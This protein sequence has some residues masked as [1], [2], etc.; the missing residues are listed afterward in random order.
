MEDDGNYF[1]SI[2]KWT[3]ALEVNLA[4]LLCVYVFAMICTTNGL[5]RL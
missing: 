2:P 5:E 1:I 3:K 4:L